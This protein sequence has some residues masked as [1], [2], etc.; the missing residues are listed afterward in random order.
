MK[1]VLFIAFPLGTLGKEIRGLTDLSSAKVVQLKDDLKREFE[2]HY[3]QRDEHFNRLIT[4]RMS[5]LK[6]T[7]MNLNQER[8]ESKTKLEL[9]EKKVDRIESK[10]ELIEA[11]NTSQ[12]HQNKFDYIQLSK[13]HEKMGQ[14]MKV[15][16]QKL[17]SM[18][19]KMSSPINKA[20][21]IE[22]LSSK[23]SEI[24]GIA[25]LLT[26][27]VAFI[28]Q[29]LPSIQDDEQVNLSHVQTRLTALEA[30]YKS[31]TPLKEQGVIKY[32]LEQAV[33]TENALDNH[34]NDLKQLSSILTNALNTKEKEQEDQRLSREKL[35]KQVATLSESF[36]IASF[37]IGKL[38]TVTQE[39]YRTL[40]PTVKKVDTHE[41][42]LIELSA[43]VND[44]A[45]YHLELVQSE[46]AMA[47]PTLEMG[48]ATEAQKEI[49]DTTTLAMPVSQDNQHNEKIKT[50]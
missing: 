48:Q 18:S 19:T 45:D 46:E 41:E 2:R 22:L 37:A 14:E 4:E 25:N 5:D 31:I 39:Q 27:K 17:D 36:K 9:L 13:K 28:E 8:I 16:E 3:T 42:N 10:F 1:F 33:Q 7:V 38:Q 40:L 12:G 15:L 26:T 29:K 43:I 24:D 6:L 11:E 35:K 49:H 44:I 34:S 50:T 32:L 30:N 20:K 47:D 23:V 21:K